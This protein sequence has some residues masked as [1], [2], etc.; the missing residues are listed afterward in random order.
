MAFQPSACTGWKLSEKIGVVWARS[1]SAVEAR[2]RAT[3]TKRRCRW[4]KKV[5]GR[6]ARANRPFCPKVS[7]IVFIAEA[8]IEVVTVVIYASVKGS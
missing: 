4:T 7:F 3:A 8:K 6:E 2:P 1:S 5:E